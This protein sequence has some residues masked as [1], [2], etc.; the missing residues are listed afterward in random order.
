MSKDQKKSHPKELVE[1]D[2][3]VK[4]KRSTMKVAQ[5]AKDGYKPREKTP[6]YS[7]Q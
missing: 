5:H 2:S 3:R 4:N 6:E 1:K 7:P